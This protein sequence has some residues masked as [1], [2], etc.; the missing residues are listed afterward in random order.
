VP[1][2]FG[3]S[4]RSSQAG[5]PFET[6]FWMKPLRPMP[7]G[8]RSIVTGRRRRCGTITGAIAS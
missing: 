3:T 4:T 7:A 5:N 1:S 2:F 6:S 8:N